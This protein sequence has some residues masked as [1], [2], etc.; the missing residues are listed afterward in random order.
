MKEVERIK[1][2]REER[3]AG[4]AQF[5]EELK[6]KVDTTHP[7]WEF[8]AMIEYVHT[9]ALTHLCLEFD[10]NVLPGSK[11]VNPSNTEATFNLTFLYRQ[12]I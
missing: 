9:L 8:L 10:L 5:K 1:Q 12:G 3:R 7:Q 6:S 4:V 2:R 11:I